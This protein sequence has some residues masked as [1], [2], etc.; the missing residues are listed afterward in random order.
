MTQQE[1]DL[2][3]KYMQQKGR[4]IDEFVQKENPTELET[5]IFN[6]Q[7]MELDIIPYSKAWRYGYKKALRMA[8]KALKAQA[9]GGKSE[10]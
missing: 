1:L 4:L 10:V 2:R 7:C 3:R 9:K 6:L 5:A 8:I